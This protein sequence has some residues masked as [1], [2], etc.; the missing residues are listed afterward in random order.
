MSN[1]FVDM[2]KRVFGRH[3][4][5]DTN[6]RKALFKNLMTELI[7]REK[8]TTTQEKAKAIRGQIE[9]LITKAKR[10]GQQAEHLLQPY[11]SAEAV[12]KLI[13]DIG[14][15]FVEK[16]GGYVRLIKLGNRFYDNASMVVIELVR[17][18]SESKVQNSE[19]QENDIEMLEEIQEAEI[20]TE[21]PKK[22]KKVQKETKEK[23][24]SK[25]TKEKDK[26]I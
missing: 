4:K 11:V 10:K 13:T 23:K 12:K 19:L 8:I 18:N 2:R 20:V 24:E 15:R 3:L 9:K 17:N 1:F 7:L 5:R 6:E 22:A 26:T 14:P 25:K 21:K 16:P